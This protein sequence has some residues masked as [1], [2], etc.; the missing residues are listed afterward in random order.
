[1]ATIRDE[2]KTAD[3]KGIAMLLVI[4]VSAI[5]VVMAIFGGTFGF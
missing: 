3:M 4:A 2:N 5:A 1:M